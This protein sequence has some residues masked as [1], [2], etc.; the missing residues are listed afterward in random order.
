VLRQKAFQLAKGARKERRTT[1]AAFFSENVLPTIPESVDSENS[2]F[3]FVFFFR[4]LEAVILEL[5]IREGQKRL[6]HFDASRPAKRV[7]PVEFVNDEFPILF[8]KSQLGHEGICF[9]LGEVVNSGDFVDKVHKEN[10]ASR[11]G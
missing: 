9:L 1:V 8:D 4:P 7:Q 3:V 11:R 6:C 5:G 2:K 10:R